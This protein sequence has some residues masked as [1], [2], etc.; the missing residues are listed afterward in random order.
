MKRTKK[1][2]LLLDSGAFSAWTQGVEIDIYAY[3]E[4]IKKYKDAIDVYVNLDVIGI[5]GKQPNDLTAKKTLENQRKMEKA[6]LDPLPVFHFGE[7]IKYL[8]GYVN[9]YDYI[10]LGVAGNS[11]NKLIPWLDN[12]FSNFICEASG[13]PKIKVHGFAVTSLPIMLRYPWYSV[14]STSWVMTSRMG[15]IYVPK[16]RNNKWI[17]DE[18]TWKVMV[19]TRS[20]TQK[21]KGKH[22]FTFS[23]KER[24]IILCYFEEK[25]FKL[26]RSEFGI[27][28]TKYKLKDNERW[29]GKAKNGKREIE[30]VIELGLCNEY[31]QRDELNIIYFLDLEKSMPKWPWP[32]KQKIN[33]GFEL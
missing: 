13:H 3:I 30:R 5:G 18:N 25:G 29:Y 9:E 26:G 19:S 20:P 22:I 2:E 23:S 14:D 11:G 15:S 1:I 28:S 32:F 7:P 21:E 12:C 4:F 17:Y 27:E 33:R 8:R 6:G 16:Y 10:A 31:K 24:E